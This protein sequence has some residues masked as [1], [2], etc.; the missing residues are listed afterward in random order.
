NPDIRMIVEYRKASLASLD[1]SA[2]DKPHFKLE[3]L[4]RRFIH[5]SNPK[6]ADDRVTTSFQLRQTH[7]H[8][9]ILKLQRYTISIKDS[10]KQESSKHI[11]TKTIKLNK[12]RNDCSN[13]SLLAFKMMQSMHMSVRSTR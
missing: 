8:M 10:R 2:L 1:V 6:H 3:N 7:D 12:E 4:L 11:K 5:K 13:R 9:L